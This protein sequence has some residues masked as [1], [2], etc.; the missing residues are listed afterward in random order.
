MKKELI[1][2]KNYPLYKTAQI[3]DIKELISSCAS[4]YGKLDAFRVKDNASSFSS[5]SYER[6]RSDFAAL[7][8]ALF[9]CHIAGST[10]ALM[11]SSCYEWALT[12][13]ATAST[14]GTIIP[15][16]PD[17][18]MEEV[19]S[20]IQ[21][22]NANAFFY[23]DSCGEMADY[24]RLNAGC[25]QFFVNMSMPVIEERTHYFYNL[26]ETGYSFLDAG[27][28]R[29]SD[30]VIDRERPCAIFFT[31]GTTGPGKGVM[32]SHK[33]F[34]ADVVAAVQ[35][36]HIEPGEVF[37]SVLPL[38]HTYECTCGLMV[39]LLW[40]ACVCFNDSIKN[41]PS[42]FQLFEP[43]AM[44]LVPL[45]VETFYKRIW[46][47]I[48]QR[49]LEKKLKLLIGVSNFFLRLG[50]DLRY[51]LFGRILDFFG[52]KL[53]TVIC[54]G[55]YLHPKYS[56]GFRDFGILL[57]QGYGISECSPL[58]AVNRNRFY[59][60][61][62]V[63]PPVSCNRVKIQDG[64]ILISGE[65]VTQGYYNE[66]AKTAEAFCDG[67][68]KS[69]DIGYVDKNGLLHITGRKNNIIVLK[70]GKNIFPEEQ[71]SVLCLY[72]VIKE[73]LVVPSV[74]DQNGIDSI[75]ALIRLT[76]EVSVGRTQDE[77]NALVGDIISHVNK[78]FPAYKAIPSFEIVDR[79]FPKTT[80]KSITRYKIGA[81][82]NDA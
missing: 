14:N 4:S 32:L 16:D 37:L 26:I 60:D 66:P 69:G 18:P 22:T 43:T 77:L 7:C 13:Y 27:D 12:F 45:Y 48:E 81:E 28:S 15:I 47:S 10:I 9:D 79:D 2:L 25:C 54:G 58:V 17:L 63:G 53:K 31:S 64:E 19:L 73:A 68:F 44:F 75:K 35:A 67:W 51:R 50:I 3:C 61:D 8:T 74:H 59:D 76:D 23:T 5:I 29:F 65:N 82:A 72:P 70:N 56:K 30:V 24:L 34:A 62:T 39:S 42:N 20:I 21:K 49:G 33:N 38:H 71:E 40:G 78:K 41:L 6:L 55:A 80:K 36:V 57:L 1:Y 52:G 11:G 46:Q